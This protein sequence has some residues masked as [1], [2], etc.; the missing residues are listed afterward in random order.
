M[1]IQIDGQSVKVG[2]SVGFKS[3]IEQGGEI[4]KI[5][6]SQW[7]NGYTLTLRNEDGFSG[8]YIGGDTVTT[9]DSSDCWVG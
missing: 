5:K 8:E 7:G 9:V 1:Q 2:D 3:D 6:R 4:T